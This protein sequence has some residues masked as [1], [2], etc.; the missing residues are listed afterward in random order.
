MAV[1]TTQNGGFE[2]ET[3][4]NCG[5]EIRV[6]TSRDWTKRKLNSGC[7]QEMPK[8]RL[9]AGWNHLAI[10]NY[11]S[12]IRGFGHNAGEGLRWSTLELCIN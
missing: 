8:N 5:T 12:V 3:F 6:A 11:H 9:W 7:W 4:G 10:R 2:F 1:P